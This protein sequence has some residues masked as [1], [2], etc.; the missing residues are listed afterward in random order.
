MTHDLIDGCI[1][2][3]GPLVHAFFK[4]IA[5]L[6]GCNL[7]SKLLH[8]GIVDTF[9]DIKPISTDTGLTSVPVFAGPGALN[10]AIN[11]GIIKD[12]KGCITAELKRQLF[13]GWR[14]LRHKNTA[15]LS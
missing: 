14:R 7:R 15:Y 8:E 5:H 3:K 6:S 10:S 1:F 9:L 4:T 12:N 11:I 2:N 13:N